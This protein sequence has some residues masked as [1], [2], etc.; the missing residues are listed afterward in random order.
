MIAKGE[1]KYYDILEYLNK[2]LKAKYEYFSKNVEIM[3]STI[4][5]SGINLKP[6]KQEKKLISAKSRKRSDNSLSDQ[7]EENST[8]SK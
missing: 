7:I 8:L 4:E 3:I 5:N 2:I 6:R 1:A